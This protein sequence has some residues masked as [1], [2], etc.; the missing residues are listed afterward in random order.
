MV[1]ARWSLRVFFRLRPVRRI[2]LH[3]ILH[4][5]LRAVL[6]L[7][8]LARLLGFRGRAGR[9]AGRGAGQTATGNAQGAGN[10]Q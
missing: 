7:L 8:G 9:G 2:L 10:R 6:D 4:L 3:G 1:S 5:L